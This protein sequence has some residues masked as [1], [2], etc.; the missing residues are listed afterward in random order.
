MS[1]IVGPLSG[2][3]FAGG[4]YYGFSNLIQTRTEQHR[5]DLHTLSQ[6]LIA[7][8]SIHPAPPTAAARIVRNPFG[9]LV[10]HS[11]NDRLTGLY[12]SVRRESSRAGAWGRSVLY[13]GDASEKPDLRE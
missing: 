2:A 1:F 5:S 4:I 6:R 3:L 9:S 8:P 11:W 7:P 13:G 10:K 12:S